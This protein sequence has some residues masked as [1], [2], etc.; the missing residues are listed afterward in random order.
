MDWLHVDISGSGQLEFEGLALFTIDQ[1]RLRV[2]MRD[3]GHMRIRGAVANLG[4]ADDRATT[5]Q[6]AQARRRRQFVGP[7]P[8]PGRSYATSESVERVPMLGQLISSPVNMRS[9]STISM[10]SG[11]PRA[12]ESPTP[13]ALGSLAARRAAQKAAT[14]ARQPLPALDS[15]ALSLMS[16]VT[17]LTLSATP[18]VSSSPVNLPLKLGSL[19]AR[20]AAKAAGTDTVGQSGA[21]LISALSPDS[22]PRVL[23]TLA[24]LRK[25]SGGT[26]LSLDVSNLTSGLRGA[27]LHSARSGKSA[28]AQ[29]VKRAYRSQSHSFY[30]ELF[31]G[32]GKR[33]LSDTDAFDVRPPKGETACWFMLD[34]EG[35]G[36]MDILIDADASDG[37]SF[38]VPEFVDAVVA[39]WAPPVTPEQAAEYAAAAAAADPYTMNIHIVVAPQPVF[40]VANPEGRS[41]KVVRLGFAGCDVTLCMTDE[42]LNLRVALDALQGEV[43]VA[44]V[45][46]VRGGDALL[47]LPMLK[48]TRVAL[49]YNYDYPQVGV[50]ASEFVDVEIGSR[51]DLFL[52]LQDLIVLEKIAGSFSYGDGQQG[53]AVEI[54][55]SESNATLE[56]SAK[57]KLSEDGAASEDGVSTFVRQQM[58]V[59]LPGIM[60]ELLDDHH[61]STTM[62]LIQLDCDAVDLALM[63]WSSQVVTEF[64]L[65]VGLSFMNPILARY[66]PIFDQAFDM[67]FLVHTGAFGGTNVQLSA[68]N[69][70][71]IV[72]SS[73]ALSTMAR[74]ARSYHF[75]REAS[76]AP[77]GPPLSDSS[78]N[79]LDR[80]KGEFWVHNETGKTI[81]VHFAGELC[82]MLRPGSAPVP[83]EL[84]RDRRSLDSEEEADALEVAQLMSVMPLDMPVTLEVEGFKPVRDVAFHRVGDYG[85]MLTDDG[86]RGA[87]PLPDERT[88]PLLTWRVT[89]SEHV[90]G[91]LSEVNERHIYVRSGVTV[92]NHTSAAFDVQLRDP[93]NK[94]EGTTDLSVDGGGSTLALPLHHRGR[95]TLFLR[96]SP[97]NVDAGHAWSKNGIALS[98]IDHDAG[99]PQLFRLNGV[100]VYVRIERRETIG[101]S[102]LV[103]ALPA[104]HYVIHIDPVLRIENLCVAAVSL[105]LFNESSQDTQSSAIVVAP[106]QAAA[107]MHVDPERDVSF[108]SRFSGVRWSKP[109]RAATASKR[110]LGHKLADHVSMV[111]S[112]GR[113]LRV[114]LEHEDD[115][116]SR[117]PIMRMYVHCV[118]AGVR[119]IVH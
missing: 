101:G 118:R 83:I 66:E 25:G 49:R 1:L 28:G 5:K 60:M 70:L 29:E 47:L 112:N 27:G 4:C 117:V 38:Y 85:F 94:Q 35:G 42:A 98:A 87:K 32:A 52:S 116:L 67:N 80:D 14:E 86:S 88:R 109:T 75:A 22:S 107:V 19:A 84:M 93:A 24:E 17:Q 102:G 16:E 51:L 110:H 76:L 13:L 108:K 103:R 81:K 36:D 30:R 2:A 44:S 91:N 53:A 46:E 37:G 6:A 78:D 79:P 63:N 41:S 82:V 58:Q 92:R 7:L 99:E 11:S 111:D 26:T 68:T 106:G 12:L 31:F 39:F 113:K 10:L 95:G 15:S 72:A 114:L 97:K 56:Q 69:S 48:P 74:L 65:R 64:G 100:F 43:G 59:A 119:A 89:L 55:E 18:P 8:A 45:E 21:S 115:A 77:Q 61:G 54:G 96:P 3:D 73:E 9:D 71:D 40:L 23:P 90:H 34:M 62:P 57:T 105:R 50:S 33:K 104:N 20:R